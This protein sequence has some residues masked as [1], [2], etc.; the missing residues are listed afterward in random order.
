MPAGREVWHGTN[1]NV[2]VYLDDGDGNQLSGGPVLS[3][4][5]WQN[6]SISAIMEQIRRPVTGRAKKKITNRAFEY[7]ASIEHFYFRKAEEIRLNDVFNRQQA[8]QF[9]VALVKDHYTDTAPLENDDHLL[10]ICRA[11]RWKLNGEEND[12]LI[13]TA[14]FAAEDFE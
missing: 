1:A 11:S 13:M 5:F 10:K 9:K 4:C 2:E 12:I 14:S 7:E 6:F 3:Y 8:L